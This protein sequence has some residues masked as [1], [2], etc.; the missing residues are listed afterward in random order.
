M[1]LLTL[2]VNR[3]DPDPA[4][5]CHGRNS[6]VPE[7]TRTAVPVSD[8]DT[9]VHIKSKA[10]ADSESCKFITLGVHVYHFSNSILH[11]LFPTR[12]LTKNAASEIRGAKGA[13]VRVGIW[14]FSFLLLFCCLCKLWAD[15]LD[16]EQALST[17]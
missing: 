17:S 3:Q 10:A 14:K 7:A 12:A 16:L 15:F 4:D 8:R 13:C 2:P 6:L 1:Q 9:A 5:V 11:T